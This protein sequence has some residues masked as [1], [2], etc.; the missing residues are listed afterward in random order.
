MLT[1]QLLIS[2]DPWLGVVVDLW[3]QQYCEQS[4]RALQSLSLQHFQCLQTGTE[5]CFMNHKLQKFLEWKL[6]LLITTHVI[7]LE[8]TKSEQ[9]HT[10]IQPR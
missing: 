8:K 5:V 3:W 2:A 10:K 4:G 1:Y 9:V 7:V 6:Y